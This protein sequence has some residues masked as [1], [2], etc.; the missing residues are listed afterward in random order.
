MIVK[1]TLINPPQIF[2]K[3]QVASGVTPPLG[4]AYLASY[5]IHRKCPVQ[6][7][8]ALG[9]APEKISAFKKESFLR[10][11]SFEEIVNKIDPQSQLIGI[12][13]L[14]SFAYPA[15]EILFRKIHE[16]YPDKTIIL[17]GPH[18]SAL[19]KEILLQNPQVSFVALG[20][21]E[22]SLFRLV[23]H[24][25]GELDWNE[26]TGIAT[27]NGDEKVLLLEST[28]RIS[29]LEQTNIPF[30]ARHL[31]PMENYIKA[32]E[33]HGPSLGRWTSMLSSRGCP[34]GCTFCES[35]RT[36]WFARSARDVVDEMEHCI[37]EYGISEF[38]FEDDNMT[39]NKSRL[40][41]ICDEIL[42]RGLNIK[43]QTPN[44]IR[45]SITDEEMLRKMKASGCMHITLA[46]ESGSER[47]LK[48]IVVK[49]RDFD[50][51]QLKD[52]GALAHKIGLKVAAF[53]IL[54]LPGET[55]EDMEMT[56][57][58]GKELAKAGVDEA[59]FSLFIPLPGTPLWD[60]V[61]D[62]LENV[63]LLDLLAAGDLNRAK[64]WNAHIS[65]DELNAYRR[66]AY[67]SFFFTR[68]IYHPLSFLKSVSNVFRNI[69]ETKTERTLRQFLK[70]FKIKKKKFTSVNEHVP[71]VQEDLNAYPYD[72]TASMKVLFQNG[73]QHAY[74]HSLLKTYR[75]I[76]KE[77]LAFISPDKNKP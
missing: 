27:R 61:S 41:E 20:E 45:A 75:L 39:I 59:A 11:L 56:I 9:E 16:R 14:F 17:G 77:F 76:L 64:S 25:D 22:E 28:K 21:G 60:A 18:P 66:R 1:T 26:L 34:Y 48:D 68:M 49:G 46:P 65:D 23:R 4:I 29:D 32:Q 5:L 2:T 54:G 50:L 38:H 47:V 73:P 70:R 67:L 74:G 52:C 35:R 43:W 62:Q 10:G 24:L 36:K 12:S 7:I 71:A 58:Y 57:Q 53:L 31:L 13:N 8:D 3:S 40:I 44:G 6:V 42:K 69:E 51:E 19:Y 63:D 33:S 30:P 72:A 37:Q 55:K 15:V